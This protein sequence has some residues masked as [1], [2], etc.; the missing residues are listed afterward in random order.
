VDARFWQK[1]PE[2]GNTRYSASF[3]S[4]SPNPIDCAVKGDQI[5]RPGGPPP[6]QFKPNTEGLIPVEYRVTGH[7]VNRDIDLPG[8]TRRIM[9]DVVKP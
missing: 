4:L 1:W 5:A 9:L 6:M 7:V 2:R 8:T 3:G